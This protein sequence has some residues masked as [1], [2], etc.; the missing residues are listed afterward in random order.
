VLTSRTGEMV[1]LALVLERFQLTPAR[2][3][4]RR[5]SWRTRSA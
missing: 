4:L 3:L 5:S 1:V 2:S